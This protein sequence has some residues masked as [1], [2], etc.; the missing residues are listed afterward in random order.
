MRSPNGRRWTDIKEK[1]SEMIGGW[2]CE[3][4]GLEGNE[5]T[6]IG[7]H[8]IPRKKMRG[9]LMIPDLCRLR[10]RECEIENHQQYRYGNPP[11][12]QKKINETARKA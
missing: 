7:H 2:K 3:S 4:C 8:C 6:I 1:R 5:R 11:D 9:N 12:D 10:C